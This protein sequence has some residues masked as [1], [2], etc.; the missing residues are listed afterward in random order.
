MKKKN[1]NEKIVIYN[2]NTD[3]TITITV[4]EKKTSLKNSNIILDMCQLIRVF[5]QFSDVLQKL[6]ES[7]PTLRPLNDHHRRRRGSGRARGGVEEI[8]RKGKS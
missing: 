2:K 3:C 8:G 6:G 4:T 5:C 7:W 1:F